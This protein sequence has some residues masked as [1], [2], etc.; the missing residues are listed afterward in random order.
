MSDTVHSPEE[1]QTLV[2]PLVGLTVALPWKGHGSAIFLELGKLSPL[3]SKRQHHNK[4][5]ACISVEWDWR[6]ESRSSVLYGSSNSRPKIEQGIATLSGAVIQGI[7]LAGPVPEIVVQFSN[8]HC[9]RSMVMV[10][11]DPEWSIRLPDGS[12]AYATAGK[13]LVGEGAPSGLTEAEQ[14]SFD[15]AERAAGRWGIPSTEPARGR[16]INCEWFVSLDGDGHLLDYGACISSE[17]S[18]DGR[19]VNRDSGCS[20]FSANAET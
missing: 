5:E 8:G 9:L 11:G 7:S 1:F 12:Y 6:V 16:C 10:T 18:L 20:Y 15:L 17:S 2:Q 14:K 4:G 19:V 13:L 3:E